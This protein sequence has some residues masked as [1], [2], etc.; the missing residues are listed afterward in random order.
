MAH[1]NRYSR[2]PSMKD[3]RKANRGDLLGERFHVAQL[4]FKRATIFNDDFDEAYL[5]HERL[6]F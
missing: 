6:P 2:F 3:E 1:E 5:A 4:A